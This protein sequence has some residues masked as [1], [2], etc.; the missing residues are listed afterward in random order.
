MT[1][2]AAVEKRPTGAAVTAALTPFLGLPVTVGL[3]GW[4]LRADGEVSAVVRL[5]EAWA[6]GGWA[7]YLVLAVGGAASLVCAGLM[8]VGVQRGSVALLACAPLSAL[9]VAVGALGYLNGMQNAALALA[10]VS[11]ADRAALMAGATSEALTGSAFGF[12][13]SAALLLCLS[14]GC[15]FGLAAQAGVARTVV[16]L[17][18]A[19]FLTLAL[20]AVAALVRLTAVMALFRALA[21]VT[22]ADRLAVLASA[23]GEL[24]VHRVPF[25]VLLALLLAVLAGAFVT[26]KTTSPRAAVLLPVLG[27][28]GL[29]GHGL[30][31]GARELADARVRALHAPDLARGFMHLPG[32]GGLD[33]WRCLRANTISSCLPGEPPEEL[34]HEALVDELAASQRFLLHLVGDEPAV[35]VGVLPD[36]GAPALW[37][38]VD[39]ALEAGAQTLVLVGEVEPEP[40]VAP[41]ELAAVAALFQSR[42]RGAA[43]WLA[44]EAERC[45]TPCAFAEAQ[46][47]V[48]QVGGARWQ[49]APFAG[50]PDELVDEVLLRADR[51]MT[52]QTLARL[53]LAAAA[54]QKRLVLVLAAS[55]R[56]E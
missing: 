49:P 56:D 24:A 18:G 12:S 27:L 20:L 4:A 8:F 53:S 44:R 3:F 42:A 26:L 7:M 9:L 29:V 31:V 28:G 5:T 43:V 54:H 47:D 25:L 35:A 48:L 41:T 51:A 37:A 36:A 38:F 11:P 45:A 32:F 46:G 55:P 21:N 14:L 16:G 10:Q 15:L 19:T 39:A 30:Q 13:A 1:E 23:S 33:A 52:P 34:G 50:R 2:L 6:G 17:A 22:P 40:V